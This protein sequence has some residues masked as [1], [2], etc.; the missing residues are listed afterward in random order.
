VVTVDAE[1][2]V[3]AE[4]FSGPAEP[5]PPASGEMSVRIHRGAQE[6]GGSCVEVEYRGSRIVL[7]V[8]KPLWAGWDEV[9]PLPAVPGLADGSDPSLAGVVISHPHLDHYGLIDQVD[10]RVP[11]YIGRE[12]SLLLVEA[13][14]FSAAGV[15]IQPTGYLEDRVP[16]QIGA[17][18]VTPYLMDHSGFDSY[19]LLVEAGGHR[20]F[21]TG[22]IRGHGRKARLFDELLADPPLPIDALLCEGTHI[23]HA[24]ADDVPNEPARSEQDVEVSL[25]QRMGETAGV[26][27]IISSAQNVDRLVTVYRACKRAGR[28]LVTDLYT[29]SLV[30]AIGR[31]TIPQPGF[32]DYKVYVPNRQRVLVK[33]SG[34]FDRMKLVQECRVFPKW[35]VEH[36]SEVT[37]LLP[38]SAT[39]EL[40][41]DGVLTDG[42]VVWSM[43]PGYLDEPSGQRLMHSLELAGIPFVM[44]HSSGHASITDLQRLVAALDP[45]TVVPMHTEGADRYEEFFE[46]VVPQADGTWWSVGT[47]LEDDVHSTSL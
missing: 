12:A 8:G 22:D 23:H 18:A 24:A 32:P 26:V 46:H 31:D 7:D 2:N 34:E 47:C 14:F 15:T 16:L 40:L 5:V 38:S 33:T 35:L 28:T 4:V 37:L 10:P 41:R 25:A 9:V 27:S 42:V 13:E 3:Q 17:F 11:I 36:A 6:I 43:W 30:H 19:S 45:G 29:A 21:Y 1:S 20:L 39:A 44:D